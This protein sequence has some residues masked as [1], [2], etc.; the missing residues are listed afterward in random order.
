MSYH[1]ATGPKVV[2]ELHFPLLNPLFQPELGEMQNEVAHATIDFLDITLKGIPL[3]VSSRYTERYMLFSIC[4]ICL[5]TMSPFLA[6]GSLLV[7]GDNRLQAGDFVIGQ[8]REMP[9]F[10]F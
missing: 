1:T 4:L 9:S 10:R 6:S 5:S 2:F 8:F 3:R 7:V